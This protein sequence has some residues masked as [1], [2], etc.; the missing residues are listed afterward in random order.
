MDVSSK[1]DL[2]LGVLWTFGSNLQTRVNAFLFY[3]VHVSVS[4]MHHVASLI[5]FLSTLHLSF[6]EK[7]I[8]AAKVMQDAKK[9][10]KTPKHLTL[11][12]NEDKVD[13]ADITNII[14]WS[15]FMGIP[16]ITIAD[17]KGILQNNCIK[18][19][20]EFEDKFKVSNQ[21]PSQ[22]SNLRFHAGQYSDAG[23]YSAVTCNVVLTSLQHGRNNFVNCIQ[24]LCENLAADKELKNK[25]DAKS[26]DQKLKEIN[27][28]LED[29]DFAITFG[30]YYSHWGFQPWNIRLTEILYFSTL[31]R[32]TYF[33]YRQCLR[34]FARCEQRLGS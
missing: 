26:F 27:G 32:I 5:H 13:F 31:R 23:D 8:S 34:K 20:K 6:P 22:A 12:I 25:F 1:K 28:S 3:I 11:L 30:P 21:A 15:F 10:A 9:L 7:T 16:C 33:K 17:K 19:Q 18:L 14:Y 4:A 29:P 24:N 2:S